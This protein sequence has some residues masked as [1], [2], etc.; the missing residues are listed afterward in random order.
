V[1]LFV[2]VDIARFNLIALLLMNTA[3]IIRII[4][5]TAYL[6]YHIFKDS[7]RLK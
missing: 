1:L 2:L 5:Q 7:I 4:F 6:T 3:V